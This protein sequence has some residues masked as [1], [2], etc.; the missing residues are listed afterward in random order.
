MNT[1]KGTQVFLASTLTGRERLKEVLV[2]GLSK[3]REMR[4]WGSE[5]Q[6]IGKMRDE[7]LSPGLT[8]LY[9]ETFLHDKISGMLW[10]SITHPPPEKKRSCINNPQYLKVP[11]QRTE[12]FITKLKIS[13]YYLW[14]SQEGGGQD[15]TTLGV[16]LSS[17]YLGI[18]GYPRDTS[19]HFTIFLRTELLS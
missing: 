4:S 13:C 9:A 19:A 16:G 12:A 6:K 15:T 1:S 18:G 3:Y 7:E 8:L 17:W 5:Q 14:Q 11:L 10:G 2:G